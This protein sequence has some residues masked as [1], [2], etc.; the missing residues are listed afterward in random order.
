MTVD[1]ISAGVVLSEFRCRPIAHLLS[2]SGTVAAVVWSATILA[3]RSFGLPVVEWPKWRD[4]RPAIG[5]L[6]VGFD[7]EDVGQ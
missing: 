6:D 7:L 1:A 3:L 4:L 5:H 2:A